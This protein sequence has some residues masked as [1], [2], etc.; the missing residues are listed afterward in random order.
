MT[1]PDSLTYK[2]IRFKPDPLKGFSFLAYVDQGS[3]VSLAYMASAPD[4]A[5][6][7][8]LMSMQRETTT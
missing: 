3:G 7:G 2:V 1:T 5:L 8:L 6:K 4:V